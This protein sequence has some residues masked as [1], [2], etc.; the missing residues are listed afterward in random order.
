M[1]IFESLESDVRAYCR[2]WPV[3]F[4]RARGTHLFTTD[5]TPYLDFFAGAGSLNYG[6][7]NPL[8]KQ[9]VIDYLHRDGV[10]NALDMHT[11]AKA[12]L[13][14]TF[15]A[16]VLRPRGLR[17]KVMFPGPAGANAVEAALKLARKVTGRRTVVHFTDSFHGMTLGALSVS[18]NGAT[19][20]TAGIPFDHTVQLPYGGPD[21]DAFDRCLAD[22]EPAAVILETLQGEGGLNGLSAEWLTGLA[23]RCRRSGVL[24]IVDDVQM[25]CGRTGPFFSFET[26]GLVPDIVCL[27]KSIGGYGL[28]LALTLIRPEL[29]VWRP[30]EHSGTFRG[31]NLAFVAGAE[32]LRV[33]WNDDVLQRSVLAKGERA[34]AALARIADRHPAGEVTVHGRGLARGLRFQEARRGREVTAEAFARGLL[35]ETS[36]PR[37]DVVK[38]IPPLTLSEAELDE[39]LDIIEQSVLATAGLATARSAPA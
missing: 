23:D 25:G 31:F 12:D 11:A 28:P 8:L 3:V 21:L 9:A 33:Y 17:Y 10:I 15:D 27:S 1:S 36:G 24:V 38:M 2:N 5:G 32:A 37:D 4:E 39:G 30:G 34:A 19:R 29:D 26:L 14:R 20:A 22:H 7:N 16:M 13:L 18:G 35:I 6:H